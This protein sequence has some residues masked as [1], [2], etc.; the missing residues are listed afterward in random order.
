M[1]FWIAVAYFFLTLVFLYETIFYADGNT[2][3]ILYSNV[4][5]ALFNIALNVILIPCYGLNGAIISTLL[6]FIIRFFVVQFYFKKL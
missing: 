5:A 1:I 6:S 3:V 4:I 2:K